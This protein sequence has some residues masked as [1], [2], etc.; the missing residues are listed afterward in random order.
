MDL[1]DESF[2]IILRIILREHNHL[3]IVVGVRR[4][5]ELDHRGSLLLHGAVLGLDLQHH[6]LNDNRQP[7][8]H[9][10]HRHEIRHVLLL[11]QHVLNLP[12]TDHDQILLPDR[13]DGPLVALLDI[14]L[15][16]VQHSAHS[17]LP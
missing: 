9:N 8:Q 10:L 6:H 11:L 7:L 1:I 5:L 14:L 15:V 13:H 16:I 4:V 12:L 3:R 17:A 2:P